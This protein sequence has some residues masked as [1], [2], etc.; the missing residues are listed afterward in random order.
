MLRA[1]LVEDIEKVI[2]DL[3]KEGYFMV[4]DK[5]LFR[6]LNPIEAAQIEQAEKAECPVGEHDWSNSIE[7]SKCGKLLF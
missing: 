4:D 5:E 6:R 7:C 1:Y 2:H 3:Q